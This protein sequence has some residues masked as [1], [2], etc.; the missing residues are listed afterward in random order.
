M[1]LNFDLLGYETILNSDPSRVLV[2]TIFGTAGV[3]IFVMTL[4]AIVKQKSIISPVL[5]YLTVIFLLT[6]FLC[7]PILMVLGVV[8]QISGAKLFYCWLCIF[9][10]MFYF[11][12]FNYNYILKCGNELAKK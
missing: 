10:G 3:L 12:S 5:N 1:E 7:F 4:L 2:A 6:L 9:L 11:V 8:V